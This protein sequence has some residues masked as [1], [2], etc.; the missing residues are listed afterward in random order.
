V[1]N[2]NKFS[3]KKGFE[4]FLDFDDINKGINYVYIMIKANKLF[5]KVNES[6]YK[7]AYDLDKKSNYWFY[8]E[9]NIKDSAIKFFYIKRIK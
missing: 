3:S 2:G 1:N 6:I 7:W 8:V 9:N 4:S 5:F